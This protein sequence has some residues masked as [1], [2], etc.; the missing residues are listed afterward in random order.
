ME[1]ETDDGCMFVRHIFYEDNI[2][3]V[4]LEDLAKNAYFSDTRSTVLWHRKDIDNGVLMLVT[5]ESKS[6]ID[7]SGNW[8]AY[9]IFKKIV[10]AKVDDFKKFLIY[11]NIDGSFGYVDSLEGKQ[12]ACQHPF[13]K[14]FEVNFSIDS[15]V[16]KILLKIKEARREKDVKNTKEV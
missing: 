14:F 7:S 10:Y 9:T 11:D 2:R 6:K 12:S 16:D 3:E 4:S 15:L 13:P 1:K 5:S 8:N